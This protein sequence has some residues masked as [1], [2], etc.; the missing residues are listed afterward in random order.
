MQSRGRESAYVLTRTY[1]PSVNFARQSP[2]ETPDTVRSRTPKRTAEQCSRP[3]RREGSRCEAPPESPREA[4][5]PYVE[6]E[7]EGGNEADGPLSATVTRGVEGCRGGASWSRGWDDGGPGARRP[8]A[9]SSRW[10]RAR[11]RSRAARS[12]PATPPA[13]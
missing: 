12:L 6:R 8:P 3:G 1:E 9:C 5:P 10:S 11:A 4:Y 2:N 13:A 7:A